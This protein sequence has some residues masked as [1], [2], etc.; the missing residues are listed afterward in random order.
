MAARINNFRVI[1]M[2]FP[3]FHSPRPWAYDWFKQADPYRKINL[4][5]SLAQRTL[6]VNLDM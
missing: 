6:R 5:V 4:Y 1:F 3:Y 2:A